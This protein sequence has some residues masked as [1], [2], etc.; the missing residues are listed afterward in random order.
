MR[1]CDEA[2]R[3][4]TVIWTS[5]PNSQAEGRRFE[6]G[7]ALQAIKHSTRSLGSQT[8]AGLLGLEG[9][10]VRIRLTGYNSASLKSVLKARNLSWVEHTFP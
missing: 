9:R 10:G 8:G 1:C 5:F 2:D 3:H 4:P 7:L 6:P